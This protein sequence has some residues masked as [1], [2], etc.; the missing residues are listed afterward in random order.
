VFRVNKLTGERTIVT[1]AMRGSG[2][3]LGN[4]TVV[5]LAPDGRVLV[6]DQTID[7]ILAVDLASGNRTPISGAGAGSGPSFASPVGLTFGGGAALVAD[8]S[9]AIL[10]VDLT[11][12]VRTTYSGAARGAGIAFSDIRGV[13]AAASG[14]LF[15]V[16]ED[17][18][19]VLRIDAAGNRSILSSAGA[20]AGAGPAFMVPE[21]IAVVGPLVPEPPSIVLGVGCV[22]RARLR[23]RKCAD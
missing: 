23:R 18:D 3:L 4:P 13:A 22:L 16:D 14:I 12:G 21:A 9:Q 15:A 17:L 10:R 6:G 2:P 5:G 8:N 1:D 20:G 19:A 7:A 11:T